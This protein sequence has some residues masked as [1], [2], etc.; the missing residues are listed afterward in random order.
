MLLVAGH[1]TM[2][3]EGKPATQTLTYAGASY[4]FE[5]KGRQ[6]DHVVMP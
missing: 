5:A 1:F 3:I 6:E 2:A 4:D